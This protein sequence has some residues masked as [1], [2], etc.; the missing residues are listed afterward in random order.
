[1][2]LHQ[3]S[4]PQDVLIVQ[5]CE[6]FWHIHTTIVSQKSQSTQLLCL[7]EWPSHTT[8]SCPLVPRSYPLC[9][10]LYGRSTAHRPTPLYGTGPWHLRAGCPSP[11]R[12]RS[13]TWWR[14]VSRR[15]SWENL[16]QMIMRTSS[17]ARWRAE[18]N[19][20]VGFMTKGNYFCKL[21][22]YWRVF[23]SWF[24]LLEFLF[25]FS[26]NNS[27]IYFTVLRLFLAI[28]QVFFFSLLCLS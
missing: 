17:L 11:G 1:M 10:D 20:S 4:S 3:V 12:R 18:G 7:W 16:K 8:I 26:F 9:I 14:T 2:A 25:Y 6:L 22:A 13:L 15:G 24:K 28:F 19:N 21:I 5:L 23:S 27:T